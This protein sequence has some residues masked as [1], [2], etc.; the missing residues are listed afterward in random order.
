M[1]AE[2]QTLDNIF[3]NIIT[4]L[5]AFIAQSCKKYTHLRE[6][7]SVSYIPP[8]HQR[9]GSSHLL[10]LSMAPKSQHLENGRNLIH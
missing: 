1:S 7:K 6:T 5:S 2:N 3:K 9:S 4:L 8:S 10:L